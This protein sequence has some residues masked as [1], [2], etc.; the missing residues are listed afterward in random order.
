VTVIVVD[1]ESQEQAA[2]EL[3]AAPTSDTISAAPAKQKPPGI[4]DLLKESRVLVWQD[5]VSRNQ[6]LR[7]LL[8][9]I[10]IDVPSLD[11]I[12]VR[13]RILARESQGSTFLNEGIA[14]PHAR[15]DNLE[16]PQI[17]IGLTHGG[18]LDAPTDKPTEIVFLLLSP[19]SGA[20]A[21]YCQ[22]SWMTAEV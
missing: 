8:H 18:V 10:A 20:N 21:S 9:S 16:S 19:S 5:P 7:D 11:I 22:M 6:I 17:A 14:L 12:A 1:A 15:V 2:S 13:E 4:A 3:P